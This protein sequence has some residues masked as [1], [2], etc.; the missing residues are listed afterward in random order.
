M[1]PAEPLLPIPRHPINIWLQY[2]GRKHRGVGKQGCA[3]LKCGQCRCLIGNGLADPDV[4]IAHILADTGG[5]YPV[6]WDTHPPSHRGTASARTEW[7][8]ADLP[9]ERKPQEV[10]ER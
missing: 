6:D 2:L 1:H 3:A 5:A 4:Q 7:G 9:R 8:R 10:R